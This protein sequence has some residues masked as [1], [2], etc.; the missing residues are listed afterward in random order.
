MQNY[1]DSGWRMGMAWFL[2]GFTLLGFQGYWFLR[3]GI[4][5]SY[6]LLDVPRITTRFD[7]WA[8]NPESWLGLHLVMGVTPLWLFAII[9][10][11]LLMTI[12]HYSS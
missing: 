11:F 1:Q 4:W 5:I 2:G 9:L 3:D 7:S 10:G 12:A 8:N 6:S